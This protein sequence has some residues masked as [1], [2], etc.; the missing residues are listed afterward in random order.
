MRDAPS[1]ITREVHYFGLDYELAG[2]LNSSVPAGASA[3][4][5]CDSEA[6]R[7]RQ[8]YASHFIAGAPPPPAAT[9]SRAVF[10]DKSP[11]YIRSVRKL[12]QIRELVPAARH[13]LLL[14]DGVDRLYSEFQHHCRHGRYVLV[15]ASAIEGSG[16][17][18]ARVPLLHGEVATYVRQQLG[19]TGCAWRE[20]R[21]AERFRDADVLVSPG[22]PA[23]FH[24]YVTRTPVEHRGQPHLV[25]KI[26]GFRDIEELLLRMYFSG[27][28]PEALAPRLPAQTIRQ[29]QHEVLQQ[30]QTLLAGRSGLNSLFAFPDQ[31]ERREAKRLGLEA[32]VRQWVL[33]VGPENDLAHSNY[34]SQLEA[35]FATAAREEDGGSGA[36][37]ALRR[38]VLVLG[39][40][41]LYARTA[42]GAADEVRQEVELLLAGH[43]DG[44]RAAPALSPTEVARRYSLLSATSPAPPTAKYAAMLP[45]TRHLLCKYFA[46]DNNRTMALLQHYHS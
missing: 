30:W 41:D 39:Q 27:S 25:R 3:G 28:G 18:A 21:P 23:L 11:D 9:A 40:A 38:R 16:L 32:Q 46:A 5:G 2:M 17:R 44:P 37:D 43:D 22:T 42:R 13:V 20:L 36:G 31:L 26:L 29:R 7:R 8:A 15:P 14:R 4:S 34:S 6:D 35:L 12:W 33:L 24:A 45:E 10:F 19:W 1:E